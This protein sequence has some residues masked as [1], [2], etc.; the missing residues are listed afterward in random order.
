MIGRSNKTGLGRF[1][2]PRLS[3]SGLEQRRDVLL[4]RMEV[5]SPTAK[6]A[7]GYR[8]VRALLGSK[9]IR[10]NLAARIGLIEAADFLVR[11]LEMIPPV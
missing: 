3:H 5:L 7:N 4:R 1:K 10:A 9:Y 6:S 2:H 8:A 11:I